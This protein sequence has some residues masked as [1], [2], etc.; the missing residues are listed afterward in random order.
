M[1]EPDPQKRFTAA[2]CLEHPFFKGL[3]GEE[4][5]AGM[6]HNGNSTE[7]FITPNAELGKLKDKYRYLTQI[8]YGYQELDEK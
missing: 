4:H 7:E 2:E 1:L 8:C 3:Q 6:E 5:E